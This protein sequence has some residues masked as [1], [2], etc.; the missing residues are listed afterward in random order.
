[1]HRVGGSE[2][3]KSWLLVLAAL[4]LGL[5]LWNAAT[6]V[7]HDDELHYAED[8][9]WARAPL[10]FGEVL[11]FLRDHPHAHPRLDP[12]TGARRRWGTVPG[13]IARLG[14]PSLVQYVA[15]VVT[16]GVRPFSL[17]G[18][19][20]TGRAVNAIL[21]SATIPLLPRLAT[22]LGDAPAVGLLAAGLYAVFPPAVTYG[23][24][25][26]LDPALAPLLVL[27]VIVLLDR[28]ASGTAHWL[29]AG[30]VTGLLIGVK[31]VGLIALVLVPLAAVLGP[32]RRLRG[33]AIWAG[34]SLAVVIVF[35]NPFAYAD[36]L[37]HPS[38]PIGQLHLRPLAFV[39]GNV[40]FWAHPS[41]YYWLSFAR[42]GEPL[43]PL[44]ARLHPIL[45]PAYLIAYLAALLT[46]L[47]GREGRRL[48]ALFAPAL[49]MFAFVIP[50]DGMWRF[51]LLSPLVCSAAAGQL[52][53]PWR[54][55]RAAVV[56]AGLLA[57]VAPLLPQRPSTLGQVDLGDLLFMNPQARQRA[58]FHGPEYPLAVMLGPGTEVSRRLWLPTGSYEVVV[59]ATGP[60]AV[61]V[62][63][64]RVL[65]GGATRA[66]IDLQGWVHRLALALPGGGVLQG[67]IVRRLP[68]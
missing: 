35:S 46:S 42:H 18:S 1:M 43:A 44:L 36:V 31:Q 62:D 39:A 66:T 60:V 2:V 63:A 57:A 14:H 64:R 54:R 24:L 45:T 47:R 5:R 25:N 28:R 67:V 53:S 56:S 13:E 15:G 61:T 26:Y 33:L 20:K 27:L 29:R 40:A 7:I 4:G 34:T 3:R 58:S 38:R 17:A 37:L 23:S 41:G 10:G 32:P 55:W 48:L 22:V 30:I 16:W 21:D 11:H 59:A 19:V 49:L 8:A 50:S 68:A 6:A 52:T 9:Q 12:K 65:D 51:H